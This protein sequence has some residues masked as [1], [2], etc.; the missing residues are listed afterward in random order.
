MFNLGLH[1]FLK[2]LNLYRLSNLLFLF[3]D[4]QGT[5]PNVLLLRNIAAYITWLLKV[6]G[7]IPYNCEIGFPIESR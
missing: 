7:A 4:R 3:Q 6:F 2:A 5:I 1:F